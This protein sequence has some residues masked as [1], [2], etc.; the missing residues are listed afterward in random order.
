MRTS[1]TLSYPVASK[2][3]ISVRGGREGGIPVLLWA[4]RPT[5]GN[6]SLALE[7]DIGFIN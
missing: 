3:S 2:Q 7:A 6:E 1:V 4:P 5:E